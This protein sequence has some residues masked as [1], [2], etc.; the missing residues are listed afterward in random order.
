[1]AGDFNIDETGNNITFILDSGA[2]D[3][4]INREDLTESF[5]ELQPPMKISVAKNG[6]FV[7]AT[8]KGKLNVISNMGING[9]LEDVYYCSEEPYNL[10]SVKKMQQSGMTIIFNQEGVEIKK[11][12]MIIA[13]GKPMSNLIGIDFIV[14]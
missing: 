12:S 7:T 4:L 13:K 6:A 14:N 10:L 8:K 2:S 9:I 1:M 3:H 11:G 5:I